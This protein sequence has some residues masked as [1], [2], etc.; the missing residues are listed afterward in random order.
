MASPF[1]IFRK[2]QRLWM[3]GAVLIAILSFVVAPM[4]QSFSGYG[5]TA[6]R[7]RD[8]KAITAS[9]AGGSITRE[10]LDT[11]LTQ[12]AIANTFLR[13][14]A[15]DVRDKGG[16]PQV[17]EVR[18]DF[19]VVGISQDTRDPS[20][21][22][23]RK[24]LVAEANRLGIHFDDQSVKR[25]LQKFV[26]GKL[27]GDQIQK[28]LREVSGGRMNLMDFNRLMRE[29][30]TKNALLRVANVSERFEERVNS[31]GLPTT[32]LA[33]PSKNWQY[34][35]RFNKTASIEAF[36]VFV[37]DFE[38][39]VTAKPSD[40]ELRAL[41][42]KGKSLTRIDVPI[43]TEPAFM[44]PQMA[45]FQF[46]SCDV[47]KIINEEMA[48]IPENVLRSEYERRVKENQYRVPDTTK[49]ADTTI[50]DTPKPD[51]PAESTEN[52]P[53][54]EPPAGLPPTLENPSDAPADGEKPQANVPRN[55]NS[56]VKL[57]SYQDPAAEPQPAP[58]TETPTLT[59]Q[60]S[61]PA[62]ATSPLPPTTPP[63][64]STPMRTQTFEEVREAIARESAAGQ[65]FKVLE[66]R[67]SEIRDQ[68]EIYSVNRRAYERAVA[69][70][71]RSVTEPEQLNLQEI[72]DKYG[73]QYG[74]TGLVDIR[75]ASALPIG[76]SRVARGIRMQPFEFIQLIGVEPDPYDSENIGNL[77]V[78]LISSSM[79][80]RFLFWK[81][82]QK[83]AS[84]PS[85]ESA[86]E[87]VETVWQTQRAAE[88][89][90]AKAKELASRVGAS[91]LTESLDSET[92]RALVVRPTPFT[93]LNAMFANFD[94]QLSNVDG[95]K[96]I[97]NDFM[98]KVF[99]TAPGESTV[100]ADLAK[101]VYYVIKV[102][103]FAP[104]EDDLLARFST[105]PNTTGVQNAANLESA[106]T[107][108]AWF[109]NVQKQLGFQQK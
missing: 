70:K 34:F 36:P 97:G 84:T 14:L 89:A 79:L 46:I 67:I 50:P 64:E 10:Q 57:V 83:S 51:A 77:Y 76:R 69:E 55:P 74:R 29:E 91:S 18:P 20:I 22:V 100:V 54:T 37:K 104:S 88:L 78:P 53:A 4:L 108:P 9:W 38:T 63:T 59:I 71:D 32:V 8:A 85:Y 52:K 31:Q 39:Q 17:P 5:A 81:V 75:T 44:T 60:D 86:K 47:D 33:P 94:I 56:T 30:L 6:G 61:A 62:D 107:L 3:A 15:V 80:T 42:D 92:D 72:A 7:N 28:A 2:N 27:S 49:P 99:A 19:S 66:Q 16:F 95:L 23:Q 26:D 40:R 45:D 1:S 24:L 109:S 13:K 48:K 68:M 98:E 12:L 105:A 103:N 106:R 73:F 96:P 93:W 101:E 11:E 58:A 25:F 102:N 41:F 82:D 87:A 21:I 43:Q 65:A 90:E 35:Q